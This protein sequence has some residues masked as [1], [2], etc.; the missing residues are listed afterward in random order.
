MGEGSWQLLTV[1]DLLRSYR[2]AH[3]RVMTIETF[4][5]SLRENTPLTSINEPSAL[6]EYLNQLNTKGD[7]VMQELKRISGERD[8]Y[9][10]KFDSAE[11]AQGKAQDNSS[12]LRE[13]NSAKSSDQTLNPISKEG[14]KEEFFSYDSELPRLE[15]EVKARDEEIENLQ[16]V[17]ETLKGD[18]AVTRESTEGMAKSLEEAT[19]ELNILRDTEKTLETQAKLLED[20]KHELGS[21]LEAVQ[22]ETNNEESSKRISAL[23]I[24]LD[25]VRGDLAPSSKSIAEHEKRAE[26]LKKLVATL[27]GQVNDLETSR[28]HNEASVASKEM[29]S[30]ESHQVESAKAPSLE[31]PVT[32]SWTVSD[33][34]NKKKKKKGAKSGL[35][36][37]EDQNILLSSGSTVIGA[38]EARTLDRSADTTALRQELEDKSTQIEK[39]SAGLR[40]QEGL[41]EEIET[42]RDDLINIGQEHVD[43][44]DT[45]KS[46]QLEKN[47]LES[48]VHLLE[49]QIKTLEKDAIEVGRVSPDARDIVVE[50]GSLKAKTAS[51]ERELVVA[52]QL[53]TTR[54]KDLA[55]MR[56]VLHQAQPELLSLRADAASLKTAK[57]DLD[58]TTAELNKTEAQQ[59]NLLSNINSLKQELSNQEGEVKILREKVKQET[60]Q[61]TKAEELHKSSESGRQKLEKERILMNETTERTMSESRNIQDA[62]DSY[63]NRIR[64][65][66]QQVAKLNR[67]AE[68]YKEEIE[69][70]AAQHASAQNLMTSMRGQTTEMS[71]RMKEA[72]ERG[73]SL[74]EELA[75]AHRLLNERTRE[76]ETMRRLLADVEVRADVKVR[77][78]KDRMETALEER[79]RAEEDASTMG[80]RR[81]R[82][83]EELKSKVRD[84]ERS[85]K[86]ALDDKEDLERA[87][88]EWRRKKGELEATMEHSSNETNEVRQAMN[89]LRDALDE[90][91][92]QVQTLEQQRSDLRNATTDMRGR[93]EK[94]H[95][96]NKTL[97]EEIK[98][99]KS[100]S[101]MKP[102]DSEILSSRSSIDSPNSRIGLGISNGF[103]GRGSPATNTESSG[104]TGPVDYVYLKTVLLQ[105]LE[106]KDKKHQLQLVPVLGMLLHFDRKDE[107][108]WTTAITTN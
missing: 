10:A 96:S 108:K 88:K 87:E 82:E 79:D 45:V 18:L 42:L 34:K 75:D 103:R 83:L 84:A 90:S 102:A 1:I 32:S 69:L 41:K 68:T 73:E 57:T 13:G 24:E 26:T 94:L 93:L 67:E 29:S 80:R 46:L 11:A 35:V 66:E 23:Q 95:K 85:L 76:G 86:R 107:E 5:T 39:L 101:K 20:T 77:E 33:K 21:K 64:E 62:S 71:V 2:V 27:R 92:K 7:M 51:L 53:A 28:A 70:K 47:A 60:D 19:K 4:E 16:Q 91:E 61:R 106:Q 9:K 55:D 74:E 52:Q 15:S 22:K 30:S 100:T 40:D 58:R 37:T 49:D 78:M 43:A 105:F 99:L 97:N 31:T 81:A 54:Y 12:A 98:T 36:E 3:A 48:R 38:G 72:R 17:V 14:D 63:R 65:L 44:K 89:E 25:S 8:D 104:G 56:E 6:I 59:E 50:L